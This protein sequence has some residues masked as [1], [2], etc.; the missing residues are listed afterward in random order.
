[1][2]TSDDT[3][4]ISAIPIDHSPKNVDQLLVTSCGVTDIGKVR[5]AN[6]DQFL[7]AKLRN[8]LQILQTSLPQSAI[9]YGYQQGHLFVVADGIGGSVAGS[10]A[11]ALAVDTVEIF[12]LSTLNWFT[13]LGAD[14]SKVYNELMDAL[15]QADE[16]LYN[17]VLVH[18]ELQGMG[19][20]MTL[21]YAY[22]HRLFVAHVGDSR[23]YFIRDRQMAILTRDHTMA[24]ELVRRGVLQPEEAKGHPFGNVVTNVI[25]GS[26][27]GVEVEL[28]KHD[29]RAGDQL[30]LCTD[31]LTKM[32]TDEEIA[33][34]MLANPHP[35]NAA[36]Q[37]VKISNDRGGKDNVTVVAV[38]FDEP[39]Q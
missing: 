20:T 33:Q 10:H 17:E 23:C 26:D 32:M 5:A 27:H 15:K 12:L 22:G 28:H 35:Q 19:T 16:R 4:E 24:D 9:Q 6:E 18:P 31:G 8:A 37:L 13:K 39:K 3:I 25:G 34:V 11:S 7:I 30:L 1:M 21:A 14:E 29:L 38:R 2:S 36:A